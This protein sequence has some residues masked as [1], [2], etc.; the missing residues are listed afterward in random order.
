MCQKG[1]PQEAE[2]ILVELLADSSPEEMKQAALLELA[3]AATAQNDVTRGQQILTQFLS[4]WPND[5]RVPEVYLEQGHY[6]RELGL[7][8]LALAKFYSVMSSAL[9]LKKEKLEYYQDLVL[10][11]QSEIAETHFSMGKYQEAVDFYARLLK[12]NQPKLDRES[13]QLRLIR[14]LAALGRHDETSAQTVDFI[15]RFPQSRDL[16]ETR[17][18]LASALR[19]LGRPDEALAQVA[20][21]LEEQQQNTG[22]HPEILAYWQQRAGNEIGNEF[23]RQG[24]YSGALQVYLAL[25][26]L[27][28]QPAWQLPVLYQIGLT[29]ERLEQPEKAVAAYKN[30]LGREREPGAGATEGL[31][32]VV[33]MARWRA[34]F[35]EWRNQAESRQHPSG[36]PVTTMASAQ[37]KTTTAN[38]RK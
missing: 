24:N 1:E 21:L 25:V 35:V 27:D 2:R 9:T 38:E 11:A 3:H 34:G 12:Q 10:R 28:P 15:S 17:F 23:Y 20:K 26:R 36:G 6:F 16:A 18:Y 37:G 31:R 22:K 4:R 30:I 33:E 8:K 19:Q 29:Y 13:V 7:N 14:S 32:A 5:L